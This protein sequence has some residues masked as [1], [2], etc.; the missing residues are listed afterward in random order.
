ML[1]DGNGDRE[2]SGAAVGVGV[3][4]IEHT[5]SPGASAYNHQRYRVPS[6]WNHSVGYGSDFVAVVSFRGGRCGG[7]GESGGDDRAARG[8]YGTIGS[9]RGCDSSGNI[10]CC[11]FPT[12]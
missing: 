9:E 8:V 2:F 6:G 3:G 10:L 7:G 4:V 1:P 12:G 11:S 5:A